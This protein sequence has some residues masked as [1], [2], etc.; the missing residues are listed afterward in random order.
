MSL[1]HK[2]LWL[3]VGL[4]IAPLLLFA[5]LSR[6]QSLEAVE[7]AIE[8][9]LA[10][11]AQAMAR[12]FSRES[13]A[14]EAVLRVFTS[15]VSEDPPSEARLSL[16]LETSATLQGGG[17]QYLQAVD[18][19]GAVL[20][21]AGRV[22]DELARCGPSGRSVLVRREVARGAGGS[23]LVGSYWVGQTMNREGMPRLSIFDREGRLLFSS[24]CLV[25]NSRRVMPQAIGSPSH[26]VG[27]SS[28][29]PNRT[30]CASAC[31]SRTHFRASSCSS[32]TNKVIRT[33]AGC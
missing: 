33:C 3:F 9:G 20:A 32:R 23:R 4:A 17:F 5:S 12:L 27:S 26:N 15:T 2:I 14:A 29:D 31:R 16:L 11:D 30:R 25:P 21:T 28:V 6:Q 10:S 19:S 8:T 22:P 18:S 1:H 24:S 7:Y 13:A